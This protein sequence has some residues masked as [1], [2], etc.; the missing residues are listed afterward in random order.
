MPAVTGEQG[1]NN[2]AGPLPVPGA[3]PATED[4]PALS[5]QELPA[6]LVITANIVTRYLA[7]APVETKDLPDLIRSIHRSVCALQPEKEGA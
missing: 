2:P 7:A 5:R 1:R 3:A 4:V 6:S